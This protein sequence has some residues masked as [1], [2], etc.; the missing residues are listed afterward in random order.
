MIL[1][2]LA[3]MVVGQ[4]LRQD[5]SEVAFRKCFFGGLVLLGLSLVALA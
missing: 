4:K 2:A 3:G 5:M 1:P